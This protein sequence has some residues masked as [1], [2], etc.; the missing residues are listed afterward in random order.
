MVFIINIILYILLSISFIFFIHQLYEY[1]KNLYTV[2]RTKD[3]YKLYDEKYNKIIQDQTTENLKKKQTIIDSIDV[4][5]DIIPKHRYTNP[6]LDIKD[7]NTN[8][9]NT[10]N[11]ILGNDILLVD[12]L[13]EF[14]RSL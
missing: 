8:T 13:S 5:T 1:F 14:A 9:N 11:N 4:N 6:Y 3:I 10:N 2:K 7:N 12:E